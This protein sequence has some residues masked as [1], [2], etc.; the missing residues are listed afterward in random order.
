MDGAC[1][2]SDIG[3]T[4]ITLPSML[5]SFVVMCAVGLLIFQLGSCEIA[6]KMT[7]I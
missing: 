1:A 6:A 2:I 4:L 7:G 3:P 5:C